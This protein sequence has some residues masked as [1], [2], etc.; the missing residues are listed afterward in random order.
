[1]R[2]REQ[3]ARKQ[4][5]GYSVRMVEPDDVRAL[6]P[7]VSPGKVTAA[8]FTDIEGTVDPK[9]ANQVLL[10]AAK[11]LGARVEY[12]VKVTGFDSAAGR[13]TRVLTSKGAIDVDDVAIC[14]GLGTQALAAMLQANVPLHSESGVLAH[15]AP[16]PM[17][18][19]RL[20][21][22]PSANMKQNPDGVFVSSPSFGGA[23]EV[24]AS[25]EVGEALLAQAARYVPEVRGAKLDWVSMGHRVL[26]KDGQPIV[27]H[28]GAHANAYVAAMHSG[29]TMAPL[30]GQLAAAEILGGPKVDL[31]ETFRPARFA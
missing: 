7:H 22:G 8:A 2:L 9:L 6:V 17:L 19:P 13:V 31:L 27:G 24:P 23:P 30:I 16:M 29:L 18:L 12:P 20:A 28:L 4:A 14:A 5:W 15:T 21:Y 1:M 25:R 10:N 26:P 3:T 11:A